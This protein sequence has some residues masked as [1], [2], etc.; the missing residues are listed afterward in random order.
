MS[1]S[2]FQSYRHNR[3]DNCLDEDHDCSS[4]GDSSASNSTALETRGAADEDGHGSRGCRARCGGGRGSGGGNNN[5]GGRDDADGGGRNRRGCAGDD[6]SDGSLRAGLGGKIAAG[7]W[8]GR[9][10]TD[11]DPFSG[12]A[13]DGSCAPGTGGEGGGVVRV[14]GGRCR[15]RGGSSRACWSWGRCR[16]GSA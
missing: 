10:A 9:G 15:F 8:G 2:S 4:E 13:G 3:N 14:D 5:L 16:G 11:C 6:D 12:S 1:Q 7:P